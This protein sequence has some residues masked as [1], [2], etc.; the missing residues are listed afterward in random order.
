MSYRCVGDDPRRS[1]A[2]DRKLDDL[3]SASTS[4]VSSYAPGYFDLSS[5]I[6][7]RIVSTAAESTPTMDLYF[8]LTGELATRGT[9]AHAVTRRTEQL[10]I[11]QS[12]FM[13]LSRLHN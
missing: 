11:I 9:P 8:A 5:M 10:I 12:F 6:A 2:T 1:S 4:T 7:V 3:E 13:A